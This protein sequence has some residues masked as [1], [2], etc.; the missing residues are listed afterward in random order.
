[1]PG[2][3]PCDCIHPAEDEEGFAEAE[4]LYID[5]MKCVDCGACVPVC[6]VQAIFPEAGLPPHWAHYQQVDADW[7]AARDAR[8]A[9][10]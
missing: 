10:R 5:P 2:C 9:R 8:L 3:L 6:P 4:K 7:S 1:M